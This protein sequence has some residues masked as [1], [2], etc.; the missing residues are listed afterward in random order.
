[1]TPE[2]EKD[3][4][5]DETKDEVFSYGDRTIFQLRTQSFAIE[6][7]YGTIMGA[8]PAPDPQPVESEEPAAEDPMTRLEQKLDL[9][10]RQIAVLQ[11]KIDSIDAT[12]ARLL[13]R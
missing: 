5:R 7:E 11:H 4:V 13:N 1:M 8:P 9:V 2:D 6:N 3:D 12:L 10:V